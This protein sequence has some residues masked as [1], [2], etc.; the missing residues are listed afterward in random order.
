MKINKSEIELAVEDV[1]IE[2]LIGDTGKEIVLKGIEQVQKQIDKAPDEQVDPVAEAE[3]D[4]MMDA[5]KSEAEDAVG[6]AIEEAGGEFEA[7]ESLGFALGFDFLEKELAFKVTKTSGYKV[8]L[9]VAEVEAKKKE[10]LLEK[11]KSFKKEDAK[12][13][14]KKDAGTTASK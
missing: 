11:T 4:M 8:A 13:D 10:T 14:D 12:K 2:K 3:L 1:P 7:S 5:A 6:A 9:G